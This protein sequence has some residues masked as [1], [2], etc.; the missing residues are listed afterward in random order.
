MINFMSWIRII[1]SLL[2]SFNRR[3]KAFKKGSIFFPGIM[4]SIERPKES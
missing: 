1:Q 4:T 2:Q 3:L